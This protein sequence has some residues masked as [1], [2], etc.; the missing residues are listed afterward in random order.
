M[1]QIC[2]CNIPQHFH[3]VMHLLSISFFLRGAFILKVLCLIGAGG[4]VE[5]T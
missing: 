2:S 5:Y 1:K 4:V 3:L